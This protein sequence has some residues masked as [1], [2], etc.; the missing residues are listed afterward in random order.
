MKVEKA[1]FFFLFFFFLIF[2]NLLLSVHVHLKITIILE[3]KVLLDKLLQFLYDINSNLSTFY[4]VSTLDFMFLRSS[5]QCF[6]KLNNY[7]C[8][9]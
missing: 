3:S 6:Q 1:Q 2:C 8:I 4:L 5:N 9:I 7:H